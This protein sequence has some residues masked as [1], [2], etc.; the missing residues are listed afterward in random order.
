M[1]V[2][3]Q[4]H[5]SNNSEYYRQFEAF[6]CEIFGKS[7][8]AV[9]REERI[10][11]YFYCD[12]I[13]E[14]NDE[15]YYVEVKYLVGIK[16]IIP[17]S[18]WKSIN[19]LTSFAKGKEKVVLVIAGVL[20]EVLKK[21]YCEKYG[22]EIID[23]SNLMW[24]TL[25]HAKERSQL[26]SLLPYSIDEVDIIEPS[27][28]L[29][30]IEHNDEADTLI[31]RLKSC[32]PGKAGAKEYEEICE[33]IIEEIFADDISFRERQRQ[34]NKGLYQFDMVCRIKLRNMKP[35]WH[36][37][38]HSFNCCYVVFEFKNYTEQITQKEIYATE[39][40]LYAKSLRNIAIM[41]TTLG[42]NDNANW[43]A[44]GCLREN[45]KLIIILD[46]NDIEIMLRMK[47]NG[48]DPSNHLLSILDNMLIDLEK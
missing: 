29:G 14:D 38:E 24:I 44:K 33:D 25:G 43:A 18:V 11:D 37:I 21:K 16:E 45:G 23:L 20:D 10:S 3:R 34:S 27:I 31:K 8:Y 46:K 1:N 42:A 32:K 40:Y 12:F 30:W 13:A 2:K 4:Q 35:F 15:K 5:Y 26:L 48:E 6:V 41:I 22:V 36:I 19:T 7:G 17:E 9:S 28:K 47:G 39:K